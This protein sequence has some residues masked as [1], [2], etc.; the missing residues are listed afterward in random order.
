MKK[1]YAED[2]KT[3]LGKLIGKNIIE[4]KLDDKSTIQIVGNSYTLLGRGETEI[5]IVCED[6][7]IDIDSLP[8][9]VE[10]EDD[11]DGKD[12]ED[13]EGSGDSDGGGEKSGDD[14]KE[15]GDGKTSGEGDGEGDGEDKG[16]KSSKTNEGD[17]KDKSKSEHKKK[18]ESRKYTRV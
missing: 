10:D 5:S 12:S 2:G 3:V 13:G 14:S 8:K 6:G 11:K 16:K 1:L 7:K 18:Q 4:L 15:G 9:E 17:K